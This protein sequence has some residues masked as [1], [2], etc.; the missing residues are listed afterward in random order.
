MDKYID[1][2][3]NKLKK[4]IDKSIPDTF[5]NYDERKE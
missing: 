5:E 2:S 3:Y 1:Y 4:L